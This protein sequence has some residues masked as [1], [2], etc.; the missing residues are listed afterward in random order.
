MCGVV[1]LPER[2][3]RGIEM[4]EA[5]LNKKCVFKKIHTNMKALIYEIAKLSSYQFT[6]ING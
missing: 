1:Q 5:N 2:L 4:Q 3:K 6:D